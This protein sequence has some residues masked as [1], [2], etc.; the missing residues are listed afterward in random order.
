MREGSDRFLTFPV[1]REFGKITP[2]NHDVQVPGIIVL[3]ALRMPYNQRVRRD[4]LFRPERSSGHL[5]LRWSENIQRSRGYKFPDLVG[6]HW[7][8][9]LANEN[10][11]EFETQFANF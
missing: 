8:E 5:C 6:H 7:S 10:S 11:I 9:V 3:C 1:G 2:R 4:I